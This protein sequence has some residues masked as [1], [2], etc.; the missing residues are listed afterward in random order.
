MKRYLLAIA[1][2]ALVACDEDKTP[3]S[4]SAPALSFF[5]TSVTSVT[6]NL[7]GLAGADATCQR[8][9]SAVGQSA[10]TWRAYLSVERDPSNGNQP[11]HARDRIGSGPWYNASLML[12]ANNVAEL[13][14]RTGEANIFV[15]ERGQRINGQWTGSPTPNE[16]DIMTGSNA[17][18]TLAAGLTCADWTSGSAGDI[19]QVGHSD[20]MGPN[21]S[22]AGALASWNSS[23]T[24]Q[25]CSNTAPRG[26]AGR[27]YCFAR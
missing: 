27:F 16:H 24:N 15:D 14:A 7:G 8:L 18:G 12:V 1:L 6:G 25:N 19:G 4:P 17:D 2:V 9:G 11:T 5:V 20:G 13:H 21:Q 23:H 10:R 22:T 26:G 3:T